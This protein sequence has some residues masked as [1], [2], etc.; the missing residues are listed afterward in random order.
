MTSSNIFTNLGKNII[1]D[2][3]W[4]ASPTRT[5][6]SRGKIGIGT[7]SAVASDTDLEHPIPWSG[8]EEID[9]CETA[10]WSDSADM[11]T[12]LN[13]TTYKVGTNSLD[14]TKDGTGSASAYTET[15]TTSLDFTSKEF[16]IWI[17]IKDST[18][19]GKLATS[20]CIKI[21]FGNDSSNYF[22]WAKDLADL[23]V[24]WNL[25]DGL[26]SANGTETGTVTLA[27]CDY[28]RVIITADASSTTWSAGDLAMDDI[29]LITSD[30][31]YKDFEASYPILDYNNNEVE[32]RLRASTTQAN[33]Y[34]ISEV[35]SFNTDS[36]AL[37]ESRMTF[38]A[39]SKSPTEELIFTIKYNL[40]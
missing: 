22:E 3:T 17:Y 6:A 37:I 30:D 38:T 28:T 18:K 25:I 5:A 12:S 10:D 9:D 15:N 23:E 20:D 21:W 36:P 40:I 33:G 24:G 8:T 2:R 35:G 32:I 14:L 11:T 19:L 13:S 27:S 4:N 1:L 39:I 34:P 31:Y 26:T 16:S 29:K 7:T